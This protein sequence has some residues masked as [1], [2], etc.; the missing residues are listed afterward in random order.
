MVKEDEFSPKELPKEV[1]NY[2]KGKVLTE[3]HLEFIPPPFLIYRIAKEKNKNALSYLLKRATKEKV[4]FSGESYE[5]EVLKR[6]YYNVKEHGLM[7]PLFLGLSDRFIALYGREGGVLNDLGMVAVLASSCLREEA[8]RELERV[9]SVKVLDVLKRIGE[10]G[11][12]G[13]V[14]Y[15][16]KVEE[17]GRF[18]ELKPSQKRTIKPRR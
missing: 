11:V 18:R 5:D 2:V 6:A 8:V 12:N 1:L 14:K 13:S 9:Y 7:S 3:K 10:S 17:S 16:P 15:Y 4:F